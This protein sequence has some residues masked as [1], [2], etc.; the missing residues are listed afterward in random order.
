MSP[1]GRC[2]LLGGRW[3][4]SQAERGRGGPPCAP[5][6]GCAGCA[7][8]AGAP[9]PLRRW[10]R[11][12][13]VSPGDCVSSAVLWGKVNLSWAPLFA[14]LA[15]RGLGRPSLGHGDRKPD[16]GVSSI[17]GQ[18]YKMWSLWL[19]LTGPYS[20]HGTIHA[21]FV[22]C[23]VLHQHVFSCTYVLCCTYE[24]FMNCCF[25]HSWHGVSAVDCTRV[26]GAC[27]YLEGAVVYL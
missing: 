4:R 6:L 3:R 14:G 5:E 24:L 21:E 7:G 10:V 22:R 2:K 27:A 8:L 20:K 17:V 18:N 25:L 26:Q 15:A 19:W 16:G 11:V 1:R 23:G 13:A 9:E 12:V